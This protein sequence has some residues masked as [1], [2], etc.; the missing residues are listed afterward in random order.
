MDRIQGPVGGLFDEARMFSFVFTE[1]ASF[2][3]YVKCVMGYSS[4]GLSCIW[5]FIVLMSSPDRLGIYGVSSPDR[6]RI[7]G[8]SSQDRLEITEERKNA[9]VDLE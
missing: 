2:I 5:G 3:T 7:Y 9:S 4:P 6:L 1:G 8:V